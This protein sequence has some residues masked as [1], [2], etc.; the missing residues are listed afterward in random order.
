MKQLT[1][2]LA[3]IMAFATQ[4]EADGKWDC[5]KF[6][7]PCSDVGFPSDVCDSDPNASLTGATL[8]HRVD[9]QICPTQCNIMNKIYDN[10]FVDK[11]QG[12]SKVAS[13]SVRRS[14]ERIACNPTFFQKLRYK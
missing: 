6:D 14:C 4:A 1:I 12:V 7:I 9:G 10:C 13:Q 3:F 11:M 5:S 8:I 2:L